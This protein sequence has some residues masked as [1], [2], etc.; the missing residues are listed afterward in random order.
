MASTPIVSVG[1]FVYNGE[2]F[3]ERALDSI[4]SQTFI[5]FELLISDNASTDRTGEIA[6]AYAER[7]DRIR[8]YRSE[9]NL[10]VG[11]NAR[12]VYELARGRYFKWAAVDD[13]L[14]PEFLRRCVEILESDPGCVV[15]YAKTKEVD[16]NGT[17]I[18]NYVT[19]IKADSND[20]VDRFREMILTDH[21]CYQIFGVIRMS[22]LSRLPPQGIYVSGDRV[23]LARLSLLGRFC[24]I[25]EH[26]FIRRRHSGQSVAMLPVRLIA[27]RFRLTKRYGT[28][29]CTEWWDPAK[30]RSLT[31][32]EF[33]KLLEYFLSIYRSP[34]APRQKL[35]CYFLLFPWI[36][37]HANYMLGNLLIAADQI[38]YRWQSAKRH[39]RLSA[40]G[41]PAQ[42]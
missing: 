19:P 8:Y 31:F 26:L 3:L 23:L 25:P 34:L 39:R 14:E 21:N 17:F 38:L 20:P 4:L 12:R 33:R 41:V 6:Q 28:L 5:D 30:T 16:E 42:K 11:W 2:R 37:I 1:L 7:D 27:P 22:G 40:T 36:E 35:R 18:E 29:P 32:P 13:V 15:A 24:E 9:K 10:G